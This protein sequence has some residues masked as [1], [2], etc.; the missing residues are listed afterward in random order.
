MNN[1]LFSNPSLSMLWF[2]IITTC[3]FLIK[4][5]METKSSSEEL[6][7][8]S[9]NTYISN[10]VYILLVLI[11]QYIININITKSLCGSI[12]WKSAFL[13]TLIPWFLIFLTLCMLIIMNPGWLRPFSNTFGYGI[14]IMF[15]IKKTFSKIFKPN[16]NNVG[17]TQDSRAIQESLAQ[18][19]SNKTLLI[20][21]IS[22]LNFNEFWNK[23]KP[24]MKNDA[25]DNSILKQELF[26][27]IVIKDNIA[28]YIWYMLTGILVTSVG[29][30]FLISQ[31]C[32]SSLEDLKKKSKEYNYKN[33]ERQK[34]I[35]Q[36]TS[37]YK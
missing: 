32:R 37:K 17:T 3:Y 23:M 8:A 7:V 11:S 29:F 16:V 13:V 21:E 36:N 9:K 27:K 33:K 22:T 35:E 1:K 6:K 24:V 2:F 15:G 19:Y 30:N 28:S 5:A 34:E 10:I 18:I 31:K 25:R 20:N 12:Q 4:T 26:S 14:V